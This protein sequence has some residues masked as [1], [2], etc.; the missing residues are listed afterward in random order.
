MR[1]ITTEREERGGVRRRVA[2]FAALWLGSLAF[3]V[4]LAYGLRALIGAGG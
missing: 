4:L 3:W 1:A 2:W